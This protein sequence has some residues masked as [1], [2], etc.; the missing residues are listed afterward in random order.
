M[1]SRKARR[2]EKRMLQKEVKQVQQ[3]KSSTLQ[4][5]KVVFGII[6]VVVVI[7]LIVFFILSREA[8]VPGL[9]GYPVQGSMDAPV[10]M[11]V[12][13]DFRC[14][15][16]RQYYQE[17]YKALQAEYGDQLVYSFR[18]VPTQGH[19]RN[20]EAIEA[21]YCAGDQN[22]FWEYHDKLF[23]TQDVSDFALKGYAQQ[24]GLDTAQFNACVDS[25]KYQDQVAEDYRTAKS[26][27]ISVTPTSYI[28]GIRTNGVYPLQEYKNQI[29]HSLQVRSN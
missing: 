5:V 6:G 22:K 10:T 2:K 18:P 23:E 17:S 8:P 7:A 19:A 11:V 1:T 21:A 9:E 28:N 29:E 25:R 13:G 12:F 16:T 3:A 26:F 4:T 15:Y 24:L 27:G 20:G 14:P